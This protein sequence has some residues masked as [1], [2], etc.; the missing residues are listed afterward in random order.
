MADPITF[1]MQ[2]HQR[3]D[4]RGLNSTPGAV[5]ILMFDDPF[6]TEANRQRSPWPYREF[7]ISAQQAISHQKKAFPGKETL[8]GSEP[9]VESV[10]SHRIQF[11]QTRCRRKNSH[12]APSGKNA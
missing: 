12:G 9:I 6:D 3:I 5:R 11:I 10:A 4:P 7:D 1:C 8:L 2:S